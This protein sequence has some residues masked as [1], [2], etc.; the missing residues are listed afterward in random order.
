MAVGG[1]PGSKG[2]GEGMTPIMAASNDRNLQIS[3]RASAC[4]AISEPRQG[5]QRAQ[6]DP[7]QPSV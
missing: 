5:W 1:A 7:W 3:R 4:D 6:N 2:Q